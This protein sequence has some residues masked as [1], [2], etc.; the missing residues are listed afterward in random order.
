MTQIPNSEFD[1]EF[2]SGC[3][4]CGEQHSM[5]EM[6]YSPQLGT[7]TCVPC[8]NA[9]RYDDAKEHILAKTGE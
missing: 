7:H 2:H 9:Y 4:I 6:Y 8:T 5:E 1:P 3:E